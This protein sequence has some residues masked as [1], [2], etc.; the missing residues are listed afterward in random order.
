MSD[1]IGWRIIEILANIFD[2]FVAADFYNAMLGSKHKHTVLWTSVLFFAT[3]TLVNFLIGDISIN[4]VIIMLLW[5]IC[6][7]LIFNGRLRSKAFYTLII[8]GL[9][10]LSESISSVLLLAISDT[11]TEEMMAYG[12]R[13]TMGMVLS[14]IILFVLMKILSMF[15]RGKKSNVPFKYWLALMVVPTICMLISILLFQMDWNIIKET[16]GL[17]LLLI[18]TIGILFIN[19]LIFVLFEYL[20]DTVELSK[21]NKLMQMQIELQQTHYNETFAEQQETRHMWHDMKN[22]VICLQQMQKNGNLENAGE[23]IE[24]LNQKLDEFHSVVNTGIPVIDTV[25]NIKYRYAS[26]KGIHISI[27]AN[28]NGIGNISQ[29]DLCTVISNIVDNAIE[30]CQK[31]EDKQIDFEIKTQGDYL[32]VT[33]KNPLSQQSLQKSKL[34]QSDKSGAKMHGIGL[35]N[36]DAVAKKYNGYKVIDTANDTFTITVIMCL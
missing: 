6:S 35:K 23:Y 22:H 26:S 29:M 5:F 18:V 19:V 11:T 20:A 21:E 27:N 17:P 8:A 36:I 4:L 31:C 9:V 10:V 12:F 24:E 32:V 2:A 34:L 30:E 33:C 14:K 1:I 28:P 15:N 25:M 3:L 7:I 13:R 16:V